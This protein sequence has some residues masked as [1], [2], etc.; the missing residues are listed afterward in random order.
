M[1]RP[2]VTAAAALAG[3]I[4]ISLT[5]CVSSAG[6]GDV[7]AIKRDLVNDMNGSGNAQDLPPDLP[8]RQAIVTSPGWADRLHAVL[9]HFWAPSILQST[10]NSMVAALR[11]DA[12]DPRSPGGSNYSWTPRSWQDVSSI[13]GA[14]A[15]VRVVAHQALGNLGGAYPTSADSPSDQP[16]GQW[17]ITLALVDGHWLLNQIDYRSSE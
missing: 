14:T 12:Y 17:H 1:R 2:V 6:P 5:T 13:D 4:S 7:A 9:A 8:A 11:H 10:T 16:D 15:D 3:L